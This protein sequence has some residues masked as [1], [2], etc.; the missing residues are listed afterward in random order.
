METIGGNAL[1]VLIQNNGVVEMNRGYWQK[2]QL[3][4]GKVSMA[5]DTQTGCKGACG[6]C[7]RLQYIRRLQ[8]LQEA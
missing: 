7:P 3:P 1:R 8:Y 4:K 2:R 5:R 6:V